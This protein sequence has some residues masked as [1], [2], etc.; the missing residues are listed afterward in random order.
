[1]DQKITIENLAIKMG[2]VG[3]LLFINEGATKNNVLPWKKSLISF[4]D[5]FKVES[6][7]DELLDSVAMIFTKASTKPTDNITN[8]TMAKRL[9][10]FRGTL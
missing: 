5:L 1:M 10:L 4:L 3:F 2:K 6:L 9:Q 8:E 7:R